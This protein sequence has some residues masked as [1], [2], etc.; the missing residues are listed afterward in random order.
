MRRNKNLGKVFSE[1]HTLVCFT[2]GIETCCGSWLCWTLAIQPVR[3][4]C[5]VRHIRTNGPLALFDFAFHSTQAPRI[6][7]LVCIIKKQHAQLISEW[8]CESVGDR[9]PLQCRPLFFL[10]RQVPLLLMLASDI[11]S[12]TKLTDALSCCYA[13]LD[14][15]PLCIGFGW[16]QDWSRRIRDRFR[17]W[18]MLKH[19]WNKGNKR[20]L[21][22]LKSMNL[23]HQRG[24]TPNH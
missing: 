10:K 12:I 11:A 15:V 7:H 21:S 22:R 18:V 4:S 2:P 24:S 1:H 8:P 13:V 6:S 19:S 17:V 3:G 20:P 16:C 9:Q 23:V 14:S 5:A